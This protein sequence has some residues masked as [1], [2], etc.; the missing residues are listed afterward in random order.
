MRA[1]E[2]RQQLTASYLD[3]IQELVPQHAIPQEGLD[4]AVAKDQVAAAELAADRQ[5]VAAQEA[6]V[7]QAEAALAAAGSSVR[8]A[9]TAVAGGVAGQGRAEARLAAAKSA[10]KQVAQSRSQTDM[11]E[12]DAARAKAEVDQAELNLSYTKIVAP[13]AGHVTRKNVERGAYVQVGQPL[14]AAGRAGRLGGGQFQGDAT[15]AHA[16]RAA[17]DRRGR[18]L[19]RG[20]VRRPRRQHPARQRRAFQP[21][22][23]GKRH[24][25]TT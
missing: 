4:E 9:E 13:V 8:Q 14:L 17:G 18:R 10:P 16:A 24:R 7:K 11:A 3:R 15:D 19:S 22:A 5:R 12:F 21:A 6:A 25:A 2:A 20:E 1:A 23:A